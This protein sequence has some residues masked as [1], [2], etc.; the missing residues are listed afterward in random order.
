MDREQELYLEKL[1]REM[2]GALLSF[3]D[4]A[5]ENDAIAEEA[6]QDTFRI[7]CAKMPEFCGSKNPQGWLMLTLKNVIRNTRREVAALNRLLV[8]AM[9]A[10][11]EAVLSN[12]AERD[13]NKNLEDNRVDFL[14][15]DLLSPDEYSL[16]KKIVLQRYTVADAAGELRISLESCKECIR[17]AEKKLRNNLKIQQAQT[18]QQWE[19]SMNNGR[20]KNNAQRNLSRFEELCTDELRH[21][22]RQDSML[23]EEEP[24]D[25]DAILYIS[26]VLSEREQERNPRDVDTAWKL[27]QRD[28]RP[29]SSDPNPLF[30]LDEDSLIQCP[31]KKKPSR[32]LIRLVSIAAAIALGL[33]VGTIMAST[34]KYDLWGAVAAWTQNIFHFTNI[35]KGEETVP[36]PNLRAA[37]SEYEITANVVPNWLPD[38][39]DRGDTVEDIIEAPDGIYFVAYCS[40]ER[41]HLLFQV[42]HYT[43]EPL[44]KRV[45][46]TDPGE[47]IAYEAGGVEHYLMTNRA[48]RLAVW[49]IE[50]MECLIQGKMTE[51]ELK[52]IIDSIYQS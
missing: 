28:Y 7:A 46:E 41:E 45:Y 51:Q 22:L 26:K 43:R 47:L 44:G 34:L 48:V 29:Y 16:L 5:L 14:C 17:R 31:P 36:F 18:A 49:I 4:A 42:T 24:S 30:A 8:F 13:F 33:G 12:A 50:D 40:G 25:L 9:S 37:L 2:Y 21:I 52:Q 11:D 15:A 20:F 27:F 10:D 35:Q 38:D 39:Y 6:V 3:A 19:E 23:S 1:Y 32:F